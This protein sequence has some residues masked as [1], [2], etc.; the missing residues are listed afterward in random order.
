MRHGDWSRWKR[1][2]R[3]A[4]EVSLFSDP[5]F[6]ETLAETLEAP[7]RG[8]GVFE[9]AGRNRRGDDASAERDTESEPNAVPVA[10]VLVFERR[11]GPFRTA[12]LPPYCP[13][14]PLLLRSPY[15]EADAHYRRTPVG[16]LLEALAAT[17]DAVQLDLAP[18][19]GDVRPFDWSGWR[20]R[21]LYTYRAPVGGGEE[22]I[23]TWS[24]S[25]RRTY[26]N[27]QSAFTLEREEVPPATLVDLCAAS[28]E[29]HGRRL[30]GPGREALT[31]ALTRLRELELARVI[32]LRRR[33]SGAIEAAAGLLLGEERAYYW[34]GGSRPGPSMTVL[35]GHLLSGD[36][37]PREEIDLMGANTP[38]IAE[39]KRKFGASLS[40]Y[41]RIEAT[42]SRLLRLGRSLRRAF[43]RP[44]RT[45]RSEAPGA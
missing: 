26:Q 22:Q 40:P 41:Y 35:L 2:R 37:V 27:E 28:Y 13:H 24:G 29:R 25:T 23:G 38:S 17:Y 36:L 7:V 33:E 10:G 45:E 11:R 43:T 4:G 8:F 16:P 42:P 9:D 12:G 14:T 30:P 19:F 39:F 44:S 15:S 1:L 31:R 20:A 21:P 32:G 18:G 5:R 6:A 34:V 3:Q